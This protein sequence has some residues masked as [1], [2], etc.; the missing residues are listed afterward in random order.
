MRVPT[1]FNSR[2]TFIAVLLTASALFEPAAAQTSLDRTPITL[3]FLRE[4][5]NDASAA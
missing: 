3:D 5:V 4:A 2:S 1:P